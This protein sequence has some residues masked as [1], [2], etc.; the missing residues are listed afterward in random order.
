MEYYSWILAFHVMSVISWMAMV[1]Y[2]PRLF[3][4][5]TEYKKNGSAFTDVITIQEEKL[6]RIIGNPAFLASLLSGSLMIFL[7]PALFD[8]GSW[9]YIKL[10]LLLFLIIYHFSLNY[11]RKLLADDNCTKSGKFFR[12]YNEIPTLLMIGIVIMVVIKPI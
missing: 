3:I 4:Y 9:L 12:F 5:H 11:I 1:F 10:F 7:N 2:M 8:S 6:W